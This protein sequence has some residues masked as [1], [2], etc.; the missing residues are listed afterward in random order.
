MQQEKALLARL[1]HSRPKGQDQMILGAFSCLHGDQHHENK[2]VSS[3]NAA[4]SSA[5]AGRKASHHMTMQELNWV[6]HA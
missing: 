6:K 5:V 3:K 2:N 1:R 4:L